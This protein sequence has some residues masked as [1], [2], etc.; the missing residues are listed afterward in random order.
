MENLVVRYEFARH[1][2]QR[3]KLYI[4]HFL[5]D[6]ICVPTI[7]KMAK[8]CD[9]KSLVFTDTQQN[10]KLPI[11]TQSFYA[12]ANLFKL[13]DNLDFKKALWVDN[14]IEFVDPTFNP[15]DLPN[16]SCQAN[17]FLNQ[18]FQNAKVGTNFGFLL[19]DKDTNTKLA[20]QEIDQIGFNKNK[21]SIPSKAIDE[22]HLA[23][24]FYNLNLKPN[25]LPLHIGKFPKQEAKAK[26]IHW[27]QNTLA[28]DLF[29]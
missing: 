12:K 24:C 23:S 6:T 9:A 26:F 22:W 8:A 27:K 10:E 3:P 20:K 13:L 14:D 16:L 1:N 2:K 7:E 28:Q 17:P 25:F 18:F 4:K 11:L 29:K 15:F 21:H 5:E 19:F